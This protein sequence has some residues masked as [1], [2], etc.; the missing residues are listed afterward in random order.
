MKWLYCGWL[1]LVVAAADVPRTRES[2]DG[3]WRFARFGA[4]ADGGT[5]E[6]PGGGAGAQDPAF[7]DSGWRPVNL[8]H[9]W[10]IE[11]PFRPDLSN[12]TGKLPWV[13][14]G[15]YRKDFE[16]PAADR[17]KALFLDFDGAM[18]QPVV[19]INGVRAGEWKYGYSSFRIDLT[20]KVRYGARNTVAVRLDNPPESSRWYPGGGIY[21]HVWL[22][23]AAPVHVAQWGVFVRVPQV[24]AESAT[25][26]VSTDVEGGAADAVAHEVRDGDQVVARGAARR[27]EDGQWQA[28][29]TVDRPRRWE[30]T[31]PHLYVLRTMVTAGG[32]ICD[33][34]D[35]S[36]GIREIRWDPGQ[37]FVLNGRVVKLNGV[38]NHHDLGPL[39]AA[40]NRRA[41]ERQ[42]EILRDMGCNAIRTSHNPPAPELLDLCDRMGLLVVDEL[43]DCWKARKKRNDY[44]RFY[45]DWHE[46]DVVALVRRDRNH[47]CVILWS[48]GNEIGEQDAGPGLDVSRE[49]T[50]LFHRED[51]TRLVAAGCNH[52]AA[53]FNGFADTIDVM[54]YNY[55][56]RNPRTYLEFKERR[57]RQP[58]FGSET[59]SCVSSRGQ[60]FFPVEPDKGKGFRLFQVSSYDLY[61]PDWANR[62]DLDWAQMDDAPFVAGEF[63]WTGFDYL[64]EPTPYNHDASNALNFQDEAERKVA[65]ARLEELGG[66]AP[67][68]SSYFGIIDLCGFPKDRYFLYQ[69]RWNPAR[70]MVHLLPHW[71]WPDRRGQLTPVHVYSSGDEVELFLNGKSLG[72]KTRGP[73]EYRF[74]WDEVKYEPGELKAVATKGGRP[75]AEASTRTTG[76]PADLRLRA[77]RDALVADGEDLS[78]V[79]VEVIDGRGDVVPD[80]VTPLRFAVTG[81]AELVAVDNGDPT[82]QTTFAVP[83]RRAFAGK[84]LAILRSKPGPGGP[85]VLEVSG[86][87]TGTPR[88]TVRVG[89]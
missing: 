53:A 68:R 9:D 63:V 48:S 30:P 84:A 8:P 14:I 65:M 35:E 18:Q 19:W 7:D 89:K 5:R 1:V 29:L 12:A 43:F 82:D 21:R 50:A 52:P 62:P 4:L 36:F 58:V 34:T 47:P 80:A 41:L 54:G 71:N 67:S 38:C 23:K 57:P 22:V 76:R 15:W 49:L 85:A 37:G 42:L 81:A 3:G 28:R 56:A 10:G 16:V 64:G 73:K 25:V 75:W 26:E 33:Q 39:G 72:R 86:E 13:G 27:G 66:K 6:E 31:N 70:P 45:D 24:S 87:G 51:P 44:H 46:R 77:D 59:A 20:E 79:T 40:V 74:T 32:R 69:S 11:G 2:F 61:A 78:F 88:L 55:P 17:G 60:Y 83:R